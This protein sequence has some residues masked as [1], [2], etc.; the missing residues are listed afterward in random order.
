[1]P[2]NG[3]DIAHSLGTTPGWISVSARGK[4]RDKSRN[5]GMNQRSPKPSGWPVSG[6]GMDLTVKI[7]I[8]D[9][10]PVRSAIL[11]EGLREAGL[12]TWCGSRR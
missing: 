2:K 8:V 7:V 12:P 1:M 6:T 10:S 3:A 5:L 4:K 9:E 11:E